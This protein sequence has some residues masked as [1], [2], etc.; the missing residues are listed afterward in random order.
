MSIDGSGKS[1]RFSHCPA[2]TFSSMQHAFE[3][4][5]A[6]ARLQ[7]RNAIQSERQ[8]H[9]PAARQDSQAEQLGLRAGQLALL[10][11]QQA[12]LAKAIE[13]CEPAWQLD[14]PSKPP[15]PKPVASL[16][17]P[18]YL[19]VW[20]SHC[21][22][23][24]ELLPQN[25]WEARE[26]SQCSSASSPPETPPQTL[27][28]QSTPHAQKIQ[29]R[30]RVRLPLQE[31]QS[32]R[33]QPQARKAFPV[34]KSLQSAN[35]AQAPSGLNN[36]PDSS[37]PPTLA[38]NEEISDQAETF[39]GS[40]SLPSSYS[41]TAL[42]QTLAKKDRRILGVSL[43]ADIDEYVPILCPRTSASPTS[44]WLTSNRSYLGSGLASGCATSSTMPIVI[45][46]PASRRGQSLRSN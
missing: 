2:L 4:F 41:A 29:A 38:R 14:V 20:G 44:L 13:T 15:G 11:G 3:Y 17:S 35:Q 23:G 36:F 9:R 45:K 5:E 1:I 46:P 21:G 33:F 26:Q 34:Q 10:A 16:P 7:Q 40:H 25:A 43:T 28:A 30:P 24:T 22:P 19:A 39:Y 8:Q 31:L 12:L 18:P 32:W 6:Q 27:F 37:Y 42:P